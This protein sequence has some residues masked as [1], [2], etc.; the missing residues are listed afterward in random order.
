MQRPDTQR[1]ARPASAEQQK[2]CTC[3]F[4]NTQ[5]FVQPN[6][7]QWGPYRESGPGQLAGTAD[8]HMAGSGNAVQGGCRGL[9]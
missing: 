3:Q 5:R 6:G 2:K 1:S 4:L 8:T 7:G 9:R